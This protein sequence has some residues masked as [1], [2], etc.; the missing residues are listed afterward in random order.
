MKQRLILCGFGNVG[1]TFAQLLVDQQQAVADKYGLQLELTA[2]VDIGGAAVAK[3][4]ALPV[5][6]LLAHVK[7]GGRV[8]TFEHYGQ[9]GVSG[10]TLLES[11]SAEILVETTPTNLRDA[12]PGKGHMLAALTGGK[13]IVTANK[14]PLGSLLTGKSWNWLEKKKNAIF[15]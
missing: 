1:R 10:K 7:Q 3:E 11:L 15:I 6:R 8:E 2:V 12:E 5:G 9:P 14:G 13:H 4:G